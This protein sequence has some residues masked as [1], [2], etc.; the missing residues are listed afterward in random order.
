MAKQSIPNW[1]KVPCP[2]CGAAVGVTC[3]NEGDNAFIVRHRERAEA[4]DRQF[5]QPH[6]V[7]T[8]SRVI[9]H[10]LHKYVTRHWSE[11]C[12]RGHPEECSG[13]RR[14]VRVGLVPCECPAHK[15]TVVTSEDVTSV[16]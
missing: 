1:R 12:R 6:L 16:P 9:D 2:K 3:Y 13:F 4:A 14:V 15:V 5:G 8:A 10:A 7:G 11:A